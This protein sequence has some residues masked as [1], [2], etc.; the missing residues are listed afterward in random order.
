MQ[1]RI[2]TPAQYVLKR[3]QS[4]AQQPFDQEFSSI[5]DQASIME[6][7]YAGT[8]PAEVQQEIASDVARGVG[9][10]TSREA[11]HL[12]FRSRR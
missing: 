2:Y 7:G 3:Q 1:K 11:G 6:S 5:P 8:D 9:A 4:I 10:M 12:R